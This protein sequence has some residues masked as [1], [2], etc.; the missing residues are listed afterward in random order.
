MDPALRL[1]L[2]E[3]EATIP[4][5]IP[6]QSDKLTRDGLARLIALLIYVVVVE[7]EL[8]GTFLWNYQLWTHMQPIRV[9]RDGRCEPVDVY[10]RLVN[11]NLILNVNRTILDTDFSY[12][13]LDTRGAELFQRFR[14]RLQALQSSLG[15][16]PRQTWKLY[17]DMLNAS[18]NA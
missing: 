14:E 10:Q 16:E 3:L 15:D 4:N 17:P 6:L 18:M 2:D 11:A 9:Y 8:R 7:H 5:G 13:A 1:W 12:L